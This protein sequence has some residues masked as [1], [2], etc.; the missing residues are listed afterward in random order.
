MP[1]LIKVERF[2]LSLLLRKKCPDNNFYPIQG[3][4]LPAHPLKASRAENFEF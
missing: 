2:L 4:Q 1:V 3:Y